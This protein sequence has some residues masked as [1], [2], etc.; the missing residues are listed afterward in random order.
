MPPD[1]LPAVVGLPPHR[2]VLPLGPSGRLIGL[3][4]AVALVVDDL[5]PPLAVMLDELTSPTDSGRLVARAVARAA[6]GEA[7]RRLLGE[8]VDAGAI[9]DG[10]VAARGA[11][12]RAASV[13]IVAG[14]GPLAVG[15]VA[16]L[17]QAGVGTVHVDTGGTVRA[18]DLGTGF[19]DADRGRSRLDATRAAL[20]RL[21]P[22]AVTGPPPLRTVPDL[23]VLADTSPDPVRVA[24]LHAAGTAHLAARLRDGVGVVGPL[25][26]PGRSACLGCLELHRGARDADWPRVA[27]GLV[28]WPGRADPACTSA[29]AALATAQA[30][31]AL[32]GPASGNGPPPTLDATLELDV[33]AGTIARRRWPPAAECRCGAAAAHGGG[34][35]GPATSG[36]AREGDTIMG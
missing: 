24:A 32:D 9:V 13:A 22:G 30:L 17:H 5:S 34:R 35:H 4:P 2:S 26:F 18:A 1:Q 14:G 29:T 16:G 7:A 19:V 8:L 33:T 6:D 21:L 36:D 31:A 20:D 27:A 28:G 15:I 25:V 12:H 10:A 23:V 3:D 11:R